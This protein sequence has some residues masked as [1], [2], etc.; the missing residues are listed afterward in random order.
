MHVVFWAAFLVFLRCLYFVGRI[1]VMD[2]TAAE[3]LPTP[4]MQRHYLARA[5]RWLGFSA[6][7][8]GALACV[9]NIG[10]P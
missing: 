10:R 9:S 6:L 1:I 7:A 4:T 3:E 5:Y 2:F 8:I